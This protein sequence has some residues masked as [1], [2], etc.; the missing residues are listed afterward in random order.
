MT[1]PRARRPKRRN[2]KASMEEL[3]R[4][5]R[6]RL[7]E[8]NKAWMGHHLSA[9]LEG[10]KYVID[11]ALLALKTLSIVNGGALIGMLTFIG[12]FP[13]FAQANS[14]IW[15]AFILFGGGLAFTLASLLYSYLSQG[16]ASA[17]TH[18]IG[19]R[20]YFD[21]IASGQVAESAPF[22]HQLSVFAARQNRE[23]DR[24]RV[25]ANTL[26]SHAITAGVCAFAAFGAGILLAAVIV[27]RSV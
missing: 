21:T 2:A 19:Y 27:L 20:S 12:N 23:E 5:D 24:E 18:R 10:Q 9:S 4:S 16:F 8:T 3:W 11:F 14:P 26:A 7:F 6:L 1:T 13:N 17:M 15:W 22:R 25:L